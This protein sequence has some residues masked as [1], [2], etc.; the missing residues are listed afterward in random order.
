MKS[1]SQTMTFGYFLPLIFLFGVWSCGNESASNYNSNPDEV[2]FRL[3]GVLIHLPKGFK[4]IEKEEL[5][6][7]DKFGVS[8]FLKLQ[9]TSVSTYFVKKENEEIITLIKLHTQGRRVEINGDNFQDFISIIKS[10]NQRY[11]NLGMRSTLIE[12]DYENKSSTNYFKVKTTINS[13]ENET[14]IMTHYLLTNY[15]RTSAVSVVNF[16]E[17]EKDLDE[18]MTRVSMF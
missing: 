2:A 8:F 12:S 3:N 11:T 6:S 13:P 14:L 9:E 15:M 5:L 4:K 7:N 10:I 17:G 18:F 1:F 16:K